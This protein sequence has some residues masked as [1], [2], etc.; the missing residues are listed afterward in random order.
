MM[1]ILSNNE[2]RR[3]HDRAYRALRRGHFEVCGLVIVDGRGRISLQFLRNESGDPGRYE[4][5]LRTI[6]DV[7]NAAQQEN[8]RILGSFHSHPVSEAAPGSGDLKRGFF[9]GVEL[10]YD[11]C[12]RSVRMWRLVKRRGRRVLTE[13]PL[14]CEPRQRKRRNARLLV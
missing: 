8:R 10:I 11:V 1:F 3:L 6:A 4:I 5:S 2:K 7:R 12:G 13:V 9:K 14:V